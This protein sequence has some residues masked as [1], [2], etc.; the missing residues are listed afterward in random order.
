MLNAI[1]FEINVLRSDFSLP[2]HAP[3]ETVPDWVK[4]DA[5]AEDADLQLPE[6]LRGTGQDNREEV[7]L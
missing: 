3:S 6:H 1:E 4:V 7:V 2:H 5:E